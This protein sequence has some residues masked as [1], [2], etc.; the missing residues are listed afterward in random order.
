[1][2]SNPSEPKR[3]A[4]AHSLAASF[5]VTLNAAALRRHVAKMEW[6][7]VD[8]AREERK[9]AEIDAKRAYNDEIARFVDIARSNEGPSIT[10]L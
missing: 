10:K 5:P 1:M 3:S 6:W 7:V 9:R 2:S 4:V 8:R